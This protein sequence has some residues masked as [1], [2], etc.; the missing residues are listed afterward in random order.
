V[1]LERLKNA[2]KAIGAK[3]TTKAIE[4]G[5]AEIVFIADD[6]ENWVTQPV[7]E[8]CEQK[9]VTVVVVPTMQELGKACGIDV[10][11]AAAAVLK[12]P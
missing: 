5:Q 1:S 3:Q 12:N 10:G 2:K 11:A 4:R 6:A 8:L 9:G 7:R